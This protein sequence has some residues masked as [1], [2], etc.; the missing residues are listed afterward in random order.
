M[1]GCLS[2]NNR[3]EGLLL[4][5]GTGE[6]GAAGA[7]AREPAMEAAMEANGGGS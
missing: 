5:V 4:L 7:D 6:R 2:Q 3:I 1:E